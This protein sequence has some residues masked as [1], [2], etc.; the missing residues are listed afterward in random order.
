MENT[1]SKA[2][3][4][5]GT[6]SIARG[7]THTLFWRRYFC[8]AQNCTTNNGEGSMPMT[9]AAPSPSMRQQWYPLPQP[10]SSTR[11]PASVSIPGSSRSHFQSERHSV[12]IVAP[13]N[14]NGPLRQGCKRC[15]AL[16]NRVV[17]CASRGVV[18]PAPTRL[19]LSCTLSAVI[20]GRSSSAFNQLA[21]SP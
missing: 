5:V 4:F 3:S 6:C 19:L 21:R 7:R 2:C 8:R 10:T 11:R 14:S 18:H 17:V 15:N 1:V 12:S 9:S 16:R 20:A 13:N